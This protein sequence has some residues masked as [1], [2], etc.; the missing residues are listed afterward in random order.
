[1][2]GIS[3]VNLLTKEDKGRGIT[4]FDHRFKGLTTVGTAPIGTTMV[5]A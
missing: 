2:P 3:G 5:E 1:M 4:N